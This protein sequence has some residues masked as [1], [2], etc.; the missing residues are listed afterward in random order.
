MCNIALVALMDLGYS[1]HAFHSSSRLVFMDA[2]LSRD[3]RSL[4]I[5]TPPNNRVFPPGPGEIVVFRESRERHL[6][7]GRVHAAFVFLTID[8]VTST[9]ASVMMGSG[10]SPPVRD[11]GVRL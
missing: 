1:S 10:A 5:Q 9:G 3:R 4:T 2:Q 8:D 6:L 7:I 11:Q